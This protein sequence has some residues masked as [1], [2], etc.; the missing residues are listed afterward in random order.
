MVI[1]RIGCGGGPVGCSDWLRVRGAVVIS[2]GGGGG[3]SQDRLFKESFAS[4]V[5]VAP[6]AVATCGPSSHGVVIVGPA[7]DACRCQATIPSDSA[8]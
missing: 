3:G 5:V 6:P 8:E 7:G 1:G 4:G 2:P